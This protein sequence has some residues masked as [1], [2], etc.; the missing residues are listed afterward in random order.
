MLWTSRRLLAAVG[1]CAV[2]GLMGLY[3]DDDRLKH[4]LDRF[5][6]LDADQ[7]GRLTSQELNHPRL[8]KLFDRD[9]DGVVTRDEVTVVGRE[10][11]LAE[12][13]AVANGEDAPTAKTDDASVREAPKPLAP[14]E[15]HIGRFVPDLGFVDLRGREHRLSDYQKSPALV[16]AFTS[17]SCPLSKKYLPSLA[18]LARDYADQ[19][20]TFI[21]VNPL[22]RES[23]ADIDAAVAAAGYT[24]PY[25]HD[26]DGSLTAAL[27]AE[28]TTDAIVLDAARTVAYHGAVDDQYGFGYA[29]DAPRRRYLADA[30]A[31]AVAGRTPA[32]AATTA[33]GCSLTSKAQ[34]TTAGDVTYHNRISRLMQTH[35]EECHRAGGV[36]PFALSTAED[37][38]DHADMVRRVVERGTMPPWFA[39]KPPADEATPWINDR[40]LPAEDKA[41]L[42]AWL[43]NGRPLG[44]AQDAP[45]PRQYVDGW[46]I[47][48]PD[49]V[50]RLPHPVSV[51]AE[52][53]M[54]YQDLIVETNLDEDRWVQA[55]EVRPTARDVVH[56]VLV[57]VQDG[58]NGRGEED[59]ERHGFFGIYV[60]GNAQLVYPPGFAKFLPKGAKLRFQMHYTPNGKAT[61]DQTE[62][63]MIFAKAPPQHEVR[64][65]GIVNTRL[66]IPPGAD[67][68]LETATLPVSLNVRLLGFAPHMHLRG[69]A[70][71]YEA[72]LPDGARQTLLDIPRYDFNWQL[73]YRYADPPA[74]PAGS[75]LQITGWFDNSANNPANPDPQATVKWGPQTFDE[76][77][78]GYVEFYIPDA[79]PG[80]GPRLI[81]RREPRRRPAIDPETVF[82]QL[83]ADKND[84]LSLEEVRK[85]ADIVPQL[86]ERPEALPRL[87]ERLDSDRDGQLTREEYER[88]R[89]LRGE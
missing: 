52:G 32:V 48:Q 77:L 67:N 17:T 57:F 6:Q 43:K 8:L 29:L 75:K 14:K 5:N 73:L 53:T 16:L 62:L 33:P 83:D 12:I 2:L 51:K 65:A 49:V 15:R 64:V 13:Q 47:G 87:F 27:G 18:R 89:Q 35:C 63:G 85:L 70:F 3:A 41:D 69:K 44:D 88:V 1:A 22:P 7:D 61:T 55:M 59:D 11:T 84:R 78:L 56:H 79:E 58:P 81:P 71:R 86:K 20:V 37:L 60:P 80:G 42:L 76:M 72:T 9:R 28:A 10:K 74:L 24:G 26:A 40:A 19:G 66:N 45:R 38:A 50:F 25:V 68:H 21:L 31:A 23:R 82:K 36:G 46:Q 34:P 4:L 39:A 54:P 30:L